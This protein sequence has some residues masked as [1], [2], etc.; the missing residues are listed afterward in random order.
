MHAIVQY[1]H[2]RSGFKSILLVSFETRLLTEVQKHME[3]C[4]G[5]QSVF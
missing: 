3:A 2:L 4:F 1:L 5:H